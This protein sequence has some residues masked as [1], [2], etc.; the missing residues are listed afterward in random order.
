VR[1]L[2]IA[3]AAHD[4]RHA[5]VGEQARFGAV[6]NLVLLLI[7]RE[8]AHELRDRGLFGG[9]EPRCGRELREFD[10]RVAVLLQH[11][12]Q[13]R[14]VR[15]RLD[16]PENRVRIDSRQI[17][18]LELEVAFGGHGVD[19]VA[20]LDRT[21]LAGG[22][23]HVVKLVERTFRAELVDEIADVTDEPRRIFDRVQPLR[24]ER[25]VRRKPAHAAVIRVDALM[26][27]DRAHHQRRAGAADFF[28]VRQR[29][30]DGFRELRRL[31]LRQHS[32]RRADE[33]LHV[34]RA[35]AVEQAI[36]DFGLERVALPV[37]A[38]DR[39]DIGVTRQH[40]PAVG[41][42][43]VRRDRGEQVRPLT[44]RIVG[45]G[46]FDARVAQRVAHGF[47]QAEIRIAADGIDRD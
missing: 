17:A 21:R 16:A 33:A 14:L 24:R 31:H 44:A 36:A 8:R 12:R 35:T 20:A 4:A 41:L 27:D 46:R 3:R 23:G 28:V 9:V 40:D 29:E 34:A 25:R 6:G 2:D 26:R 42:A 1:L 30:V 15:V 19:R 32:E 37:L 5:R 45:D 18:E 38:I 11:L 7:L 39:H 10:G 43:I 47:D 22:E 13:Q